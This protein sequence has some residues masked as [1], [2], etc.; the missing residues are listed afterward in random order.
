[1]AAWIVFFVYVALISVG[2]GLCCKRR[3][4]AEWKAA[5]LPIVSFFYLNKLTGGFNALA[6]I[7]VKNWGR[8]VL[9][10]MALC[11][12]CHALIGWGGGHLAAEDSAALKQ[13]LMLCVVICCII[14]YLGC[15][16]FTKKILFV[17]KVSFPFEGLVCALFVTLPFILMIDLRKFSYERYLEKQAAENQSSKI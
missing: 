15:I 16:G 14:F 3:G 12:L 4:I 11:A 6:I 7:K 17:F 9:T 5:C 2:I 1:M 13:I 10:L 8:S